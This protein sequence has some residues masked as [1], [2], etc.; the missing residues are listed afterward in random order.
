MSTLVEVESFGYK[1]DLVETYFIPIHQI[2]GI[3]NSRNGCWI[4]VVGMMANAKPM[5]LRSKI[6]F[7]ELK[8]LFDKL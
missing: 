1:G 5:A 2:C 8:S 3:R 4:H 7:A 6:D